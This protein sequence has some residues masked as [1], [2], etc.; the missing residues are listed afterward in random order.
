[1]RKL[2]DGC[3]QPYAPT[4]QVLQQLG[5]PQG[6]VQAFFRHHEGPLPLP[7]DAPRN[8]VPQICRTCGGMGFKGRA[9]VYE[10]L[11]MTDRLREVLATS[12]KIEVLR[13]EARKSGFRTMQEEGIALVAKGITELPELL[14]VLKE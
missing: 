6:K 7:P 4:P 9:P 5:I 2:C 14:R 8:A 3:K 10:L 11:I 13:D 1:V 12:P